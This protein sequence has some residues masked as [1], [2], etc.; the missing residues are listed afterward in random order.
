[1]VVG[2]AALDGGEME[3]SHRWSVILHRNCLAKCIMGLQTT[4]PLCRGGQ[5]KR[6]SEAEK[7]DG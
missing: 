3:S 7:Q 4:H 1:M 5:E 2:R 6:V